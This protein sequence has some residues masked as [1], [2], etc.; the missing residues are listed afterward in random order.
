[1]KMK[2]LYVDDHEDAKVVTW[3]LE[4]KANAQVVFA[5]NGKI[6]LQVF[7]EQGGFDAVITDGNMPEMNGAELARA[8]HVLNPA[9]RIALISSS[10][11]QYQPLVEGIADCFDKLKFPADDPMKPLIDWLKE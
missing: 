2:I 1:M 7:K 9:T 4:E 10:I 6:A 3:L 5:G 8:I 11:E